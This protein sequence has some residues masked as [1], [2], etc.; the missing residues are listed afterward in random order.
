[1]QVPLF[2][3]MTPA[4][5]ESLAVVITEKVYPPKTVVY[6]QGNEVE[7]LFF[8]QRGHV[9]VLSV[10]CCIPCNGNDVSIMYTLTHFCNRSICWSPPCSSLHSAFQSCFQLLLT[11]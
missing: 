3:G 4:D 9:K 7:D 2:Q 6:Y 5:I 8:I 1:M 10:S 11:R